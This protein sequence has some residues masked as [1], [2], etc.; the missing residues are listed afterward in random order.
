MPPAPGDRFTER[1]TEALDQALG[2]VEAYRSWRP[3]DPGPAAGLDARYRALPVLT[4]RLM[5]LHAPA[6]FVPRGR[7]MEQGLRDGTIEL[8][9]TSGTTDDRIVNVWYQPWWDASERA[10]WALNAHARRVATGD[11][12][13]AILASPL[14]VGFPSDTPLPPERRRLGRL[15]FLNELV[16]PLAWPDAHCQRMLDELAEYQP[17]VLEANPSLLSRLCRYAARVGARPYQP[18]LVTL[19]Y[20]Y[21][22]LL[23]RR[24]IAAVLDAPVMSSYG[25]TESGYVL[26]ECERGRMHLNAAS[27]RVDLLPFA[28]GRADPQVGKLL[29]TDLDN[30]WRSLVRFDAGDL[31]RVAEDPCPCGCAGPTFSAV[32]GRAVNLTAGPDGR[33]ITQAEVDRRL[34]E[35]AGLAEYQLLQADPDSY[36]LRVVADGRG[37]DGLARR[38]EGALRD[39]YGPGARIAVAPAAAIGPEASGKH[40]LVKAAFAI[41]SMALVEPRLRPPV[42]PEAEAG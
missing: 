17:A 34:A 22:S 28:G 6:A 3:F 1:C 32:E 33:V 8:V 38:A 2:Q 25:S 29:I 27:C 31:A 5:N 24:H 16:D 36:T 12:R 23:H 9:T 21:P 13:E 41:D 35:V 30:P 20:E 26:I 42:P 37:E 39:L 4:K 40:R 7:S 10:S 19:T 15:L 11:H 18:G 14:N